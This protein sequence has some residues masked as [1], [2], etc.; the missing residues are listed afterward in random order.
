LIGQIDGI[1]QYFFQPWHQKLR[2]GNTFLKPAGITAHL[3][4]RESR[5]FSNYFS[6]WIFYAGLK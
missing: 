3:E 2:P 5:I 6:P 1:A 4:A